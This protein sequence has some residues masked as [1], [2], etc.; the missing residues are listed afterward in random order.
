[1]RSG[2]VPWV[3]PGRTSRRPR[4][5]LMLWPSALIEVY[6]IELLVDVSAALVLKVQLVKEW[7]AFVD[8]RPC[9]KP[10]FINKTDDVAT[11]EVT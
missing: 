1:M 10:S 9:R 11:V 7:A 6:V 2:R 4:T 8:A 3:K 5:R